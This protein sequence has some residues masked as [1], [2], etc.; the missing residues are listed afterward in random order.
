[1]INYKL[2]TYDTNTST[3]RSKKPSHTNRKA[4]VKNTPG[5]RMPRNF[6]ILFVIAMDLP[7]FKLK[8]LLRKRQWHRKA[9]KCGFVDSENAVI[10]SVGV[11]EG[12]SGNATLRN[13]SGVVILNNVLF[14]GKI[15]GKVC[16]YFIGKYWYDEYKNLLFNTYWCF[17]K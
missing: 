4:Q 10:A 8:L 14:R 16:D 11:R 9:T 5:R 2:F 3:Y 12:V 1:M 15:C 6:S 17:H 7:F 13:E